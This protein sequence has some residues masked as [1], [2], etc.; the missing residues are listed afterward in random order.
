MPDGI[1]VYFENVGGDVWRAVE[2]HLNLYA[3]VPVCGLVANYNATGP[4]RDR[5]ASTASC[6][7][8]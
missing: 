5:T 3:R 1:D 7:G 4:A 8:S 2:R 6:A